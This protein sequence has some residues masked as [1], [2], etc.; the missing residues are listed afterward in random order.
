M[1]V[2]RDEIIEKSG[3]ALRILDK[4]TEYLIERLKNS[5][6]QIVTDKTLKE[7][8]LLRMLLED[9][10][11]AIEKEEYY[12]IEENLENRKKIKE[13][14]EY[15]IIQAKK[16][17]GILMEETADG[18]ICL[19]TQ[20][21]IEEKV[22]APCGHVFDKKGLLF[23]YKSVSKKNKFQCP[24]VGCKSDWHKLKYKPTE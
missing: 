11:D 20:K 18:N 16:S 15:Q 6:E 1:G 8:V 12:R 24:Y 17:T 14:R 5:A 23:L 13:N 22:E 21:E 9:N 2:H 10:K 19:I 3:S 4:E 7:L